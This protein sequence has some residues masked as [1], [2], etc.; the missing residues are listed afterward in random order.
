M[1]GMPPL[2]YDVKDRKLVVNDD[3]ARIVV[4][5]Y[6]RY[7]MLK[8]VHTLKDELAKAG[9]R[10]KRRVRPDGT[11]YGSQKFSRGALYLML[12]I[13]FT[14]ARLLIRTIHIRDDIQ[15]SSNSHCGTKFRQSLPRTGSSGPLA[16][17]Q[18]IRA[19]SPASYLMRPASG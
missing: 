14:A 12:Q 17:A 9:I 19:C 3:E 7:L 4:D 13:D 1:G 6:R 2:G 5:I 10:S 18:S 11:E 8:S 16:Y 15:Q